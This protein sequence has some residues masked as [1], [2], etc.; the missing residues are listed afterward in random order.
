MSSKAGWP[1]IESAVRKALQLDSKS[2]LAHAIL[3]LKY[4]TYDYDWSAAR[5]E[6][7]NALALNPRDPVALYNASWL[8]FDLGQ[9]DEALRLENISL[10]IDPLNP[11]AYQY[12]GVIYY[13][14]GN[15]DA[16]ERA[17]RTSVKISPTFTGNHYYL[18]QI[19]LLRNQ[20]EAALREMLAEGDSRRDFGLAL[21][22]KALGRRGEADAALTRI[23]RAAGGAGAINI[24]IVY[25]YRNERDKAFAWLE[26][27][28]DQRELS[29][30][31]KF[32]DE[33]KLAPLRGDPRYKALLKKMKLP[34]GQR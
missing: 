13:L 28:V 31:H 27:A 25:A 32:R 1:G 14:M 10:S 21:A 12:G 8:A 4:A 26:K 20:P 33:P 5:A 17:F 22:Y 3:G 6:M 34:E 2:A 9:H 23:I 30:G 24:A 18:G 19:L 16:A 11:D 7:R 29:V 15:L